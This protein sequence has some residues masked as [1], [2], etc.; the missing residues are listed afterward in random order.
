MLFACGISNYSVGLFHLAN[1]AFFVRWHRYIDLYDGL[2]FRNLLKEGKSTCLFSKFKFKDLGKMGN[3]SESLY[4]NYV[5]VIN[6]FNLYVKSIQEKIDNNLHFFN[7]ISEKILKSWRNIEGPF[8]FVAKFKEIFL[9]STVY[10]LK[11]SKPVSNFIHKIILLHF[12]LIHKNKFLKFQVEDSDSDSDSD[13]YSS[14]QSGCRIDYQAKALS[15]VKDTLNL[16]RP[17]GRWISHSFNQIRYCSSYTTNIKKCIPNNKKYICQNL[18][19]IFHH[20]SHW[21]NI[22]KE[23]KLEIPNWVIL[24]GNNRINNRWLSNVICQKFWKWAIRK[25]KGLSK[26]TIYENYWKSLDL[27]I[28]KIFYPFPIFKEKYNWE[29]KENLFYLLKSEKIESCIYLFYLKNKPLKFYLGHSQCVSKRFSNHFNTALV[30]VKRHIK[31]Y[32]AV[33]K[34]GWNSFNFLVLE[35]CD[36]EKLIEREQIWLDKIF[37]DKLLSE[38]T[39]N[40]HKLSN[41]SRGYKH[42]E[43]TRKN[44]SR[45]KIGL[46]HTDEAKKKKNMSLSQMGRGDYQVQNIIS[47]INHYHLKQK[48]KYLKN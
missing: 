10:M 14:R 46:K 41:S 18:K 38:N 22:V 30:N 33:Q 31:F 11:V 47:E 32:S 27:K 39:L 36:V 29:I 7:K 12:Y 45:A 2:S 37:S 19:N 48:K 42:S 35:L 25:H 21:N 43:E 16:T 5:I 15:N 26:T 20:N 24:L 9:F 40:L 34:Y 28:S 4:E 44:M 6:N 3:E 1:H 17:R 8:F 23:L 13:S